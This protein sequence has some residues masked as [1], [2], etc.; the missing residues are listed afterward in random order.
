VVLR[1]PDIT[2]ESKGDV[3]FPQ[4]LISNSHDGKN[5]FTFRAG[6]FRLVCENGLVVSDQD[7]EKLSIRH[8]GYTFEELQKT[9]NAIVEKLPHTVE[10]MNR[11]KQRQL[12]ELETNKFAERA[13]AARFGDDV[14]FI[15]VDFSKLLEPT[16]PEDAGNDLWSV[17]NVVQEKHSKSMQRQA[18]EEFQRKEREQQLKDDAEREKIEQMNANKQKEEQKRF[19]EAVERARAM[20]RKQVETPIDDSPE[21]TMKAIENAYPKKIPRIEKKGK[22]LKKEDITIHSA[23][24]TADLATLPDID[25]DVDT[26]RYIAMYEKLWR[27]ACIREKREGWWQE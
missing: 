11:L 23:Y 22:Q 2:I 25:Y 8:Y 21:F 18:I 27:D 16:R 26:E 10:S 4:I 7:F 6:L 15:K 24:S 13:I 9:I 5:A 20:G 14:E 3:V 19:D 17:F 12:T 1:N